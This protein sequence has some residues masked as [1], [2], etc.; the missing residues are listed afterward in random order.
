MHKN[1]RE[2]VGPPLQPSMCEHYLHITSGR[3][4]PSLLDDIQV[5]VQLQDDSHTGTEE[6]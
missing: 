4:I 3:R 2:R 6:E 1:D 5:I